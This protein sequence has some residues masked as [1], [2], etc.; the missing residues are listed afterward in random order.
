MGDVIEL[1]PTAGAE[2]E[3]DLHFGGCPHCSKTDGYINV[4]RDHWFVCDQHR[5]KWWAGSNLFS[6][7]RDETE[8]EWLRNEYKLEN[9][10]SV[11]PV[12]RK[13]TPEELEEVERTKRESAIC[14]ALGA[15]MSSSEPI[16]PDDPGSFLDGDRNEP[17]VER[18]DRLFIM[19]RNGQVYDLDK[20]EAE[21]AYEADLAG[22]GDA[23]AR[24]LS[25]PTAVC[26]R[27]PGLV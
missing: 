2:V 22:D 24:L 26:K 18:P 9:Y 11:D 6:S 13:P 4:G 19:T 27:R 8:E 5:T 12:Y 16:D 17:F 25:K 1:R 10:I 3:T 7:W 21:A 23:I 15:V 14:R 20:M